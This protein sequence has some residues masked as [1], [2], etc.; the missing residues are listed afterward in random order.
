VPECVVEERTLQDHT[1]C[2]TFTPS[3]KL[4][5][6]KGFRESMM[7]VLNPNRKRLK[8]EGGYTFIN[9]ILGKI[10]YVVNV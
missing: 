3:Q 9:R 8:I 4:C 6:H 1:E 7:A 10:S 2:S 5:A